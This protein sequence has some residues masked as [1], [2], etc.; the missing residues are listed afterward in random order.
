MGRCGNSPA[1]FAEVAGN[2]VQQVI[3]YDIPEHIFCEIF[4]LFSQCCCFPFSLFLSVV[5][6]AIDHFLIGVQFDRS[7]F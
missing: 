2:S 7:H 6:D 5:I 3:A 4:L 1:V